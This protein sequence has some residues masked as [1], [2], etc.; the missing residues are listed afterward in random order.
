MSDVLE[1]LPVARLKP[2]PRNARIHAKKQLRMI[3]RSIEKFGFL[4]PVLIDDDN[5]ILAGHARVE[6]AKLLGRESVPCRRVSHLP[7]QSCSRPRVTFVVPRDSS[8]SRRPT[9]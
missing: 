4:A 1:N 9:A 2:H 3:A 8:I 5:V 7:L 6:A